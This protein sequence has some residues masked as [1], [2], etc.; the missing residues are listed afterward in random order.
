MVNENEQIVR[1]NIE[2]G[3][4]V[5]EQIREYEHLLPI[6]GDM[7]VWHGLERRAN[8]VETFQRHVQE[9]RSEIIPDRSFEISPNEAE[10]L[11]KI[12]V[13][14]TVLYAPEQKGLL[15]GIP[16]ERRQQYYRDLTSSVASVYAAK[17]R[18]QDYEAMILGGGQKQ[19]ARIKP[20]KPQ[21]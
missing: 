20:N 4:V 5:L 6:L 21:K 3:T 10:G 14:S 17:S 7:A 11:A 15:C 13:E 2:A 9:T 8:E 12:V 1:S 18:L 16:A 19:T